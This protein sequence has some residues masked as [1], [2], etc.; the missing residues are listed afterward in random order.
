MTDPIAAAQPPDPVREP[1]RWRVDTRPLRTSH[2]FRMIWW[3]GLISYL[4]S[5]T[6][7]VAVP[8]QIKQLTG[9]LALAGLLGLA[10]L[11]PLI[12]FGLWGGA[13]ADAR[14]RKTMVFGCEAGMLLL[15]AVL[16][17]NTLLPHTQVW[18]IFVVVALFATGDALQRPSLDAMIPNVVAHRDLQAASALTSINYDLGAVVGPALAGVLLTAGATWLAY[19]FDV[20]TFVVS[21]TF[22][23]RIAHVSAPAEDAVADLRSI[24]AGLRYAWQRKDLLGT[25]VVDILAMFFG[26]T[27]AIFPFLAVAARRTVGSRACCSPAPAVGSLAVSLTS[28]WASHV[29]RHGLAIAWAAG[30]FG[31]SM[32]CVGLAPNV[33]VALV[34]LVAS[35]A[36]DMVSGIFRSTVW[37]GSIPDDMRGRLAGVELLSYSTG[38]ALGNTRAGLVASVIGVRGAI[39]SGGLLAA[40]GAVAVTATMR[41]FRRYDDRTNPHASRGAPGVPTPSRGRLPAMAVSELFDPSA[42]QEVDGF[43]DLTDVTY[44][45]AVGTGPSGSPSTGRR[46]ATR[47]DRTRSTSC[48]AASSMRARPPTSG[49][50]C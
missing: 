35:G 19:A 1:R 15:S 39:A 24:A 43:A 36:A 8:F 44:H 6:T 50:C 10:E 21:L 5:I 14:D 42:W 27:T 26:L 46:C 16:M 31:L 7:Y 12:V 22:L 38:P 40:A 34:A 29:H 48:T 30:A 9:S 18:L 13:L 20:V 11:V 4:G 25:Y 47:S 28:G 2:D 37:N 45:R 23:S 32:I 3:S 33:W 17:T 41:D 49:A